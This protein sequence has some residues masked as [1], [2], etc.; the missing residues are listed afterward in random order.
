MQGII[1]RNFVLATEY[2]V[3]TYAKFGGL[4]SYELLQLNPPSFD[5][6][7]FSTMQ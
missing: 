7:Q 6:L 3:H 2:D 5:L 4:T 1:M